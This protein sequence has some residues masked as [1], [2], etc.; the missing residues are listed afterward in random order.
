[1]RRVTLSGSPVVTLRCGPLSPAVWAVLREKV[2]WGFGVFC[3]WR[4][5]VDP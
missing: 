4:R 3:Y 5:V 2:P 1:M